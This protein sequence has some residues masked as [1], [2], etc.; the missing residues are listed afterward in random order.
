M[1]FSFGNVVGLLI[2]LALGVFSLAFY[3][4]FVYPVMSAQ[5]ERAK[6]TATQGRDP[7]RFTR[8]V[9]LVSLLLL[10]VLGFLLGGLLLNW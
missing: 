9:Y 7:A 6:V 8:T 2:F 10:P 5:Y 1:F 4:R 3:K